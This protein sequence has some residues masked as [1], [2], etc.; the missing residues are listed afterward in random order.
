M[1]LWLEIRNMKFFYDVLMFEIWNM[2]FKVVAYDMKSKGK[3]L[4]LV[5]LWYEI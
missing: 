1:C 5:C 2:R 3:W 4:K